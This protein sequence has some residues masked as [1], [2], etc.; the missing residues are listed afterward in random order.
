MMNLKLEALMFYW[1]ALFQLNLYMQLHSKKSKVLF[2]SFAIYFLVAKSDTLIVN[3]QYKA[4]KVCFSISF[5]SFSFSQ[6]SCFPVHN[7]NLR[8]QT[9]WGF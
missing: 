9:L 6:N 7:S 4:D 2:S 5:P 1:I 8:N 3:I